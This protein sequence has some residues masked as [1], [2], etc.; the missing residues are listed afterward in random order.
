MV[1]FC[2]PPPRRELHKSRRSGNSATLLLQPRSGIIGIRTS[3]E[4]AADFPPAADR[5][6]D[7]PRICA[8]S[9]LENLKA[10]G[11]RRWFRGSGS[12]MRMRIRMGRMLL[13]TC[14]GSFFILI[15]YFQSSS[16]SGESIPTSQFHIRAAGLYISN[17]Y[18]LYR[19][20]GRW[21]GN[22]DY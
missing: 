1:H 13:A 10:R 18:R 19:R 5:N 14:A 15:L 20:C 22:T 6:T 8:N 12:R 16:R 21:I 11:G 17:I 7:G 2:D 4:G 9:E 3:V